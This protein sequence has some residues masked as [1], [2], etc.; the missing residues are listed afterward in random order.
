[1]FPEILSGMANSVDPDQTDPSG[2]VLSGSA[3]FAYV[4]L[5]VT[6]AFRIIGHCTT[7]YLLYQQNFTIRSLDLFAQFLF[8]EILELLDI[9]WK[10]ADENSCQRFHLMPRYARPLPGNIPWPSCSKRR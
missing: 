7:I 9:D 3:L 5:S 1:M 4:I 10:G 2:A 8:T 6:L